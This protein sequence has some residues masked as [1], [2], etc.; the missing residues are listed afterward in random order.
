M[1]EFRPYWFE[2]P[3]PPESL[4]ALRDVR[5]RSPIPI[6]TGERYYEVQRFAE[7]IAADAADYLQP[8]V[9]HVAAWDRRN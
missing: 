8:D 7:L 2:E 5:R 9:T 6:A 1:A 3:T 4:E